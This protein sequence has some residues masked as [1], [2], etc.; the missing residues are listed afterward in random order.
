MNWLRFKTVVLGI[1]CVGMAHAQDLKKTTFKVVPSHLTAQFAGAMGAAALGPGFNYGKHKRWD[2]EVLL[3]YVPKFDSEK[4]KY[5]INFRQTYKPFNLHLGNH[6]SLYPLRTGA[7]VNTTIG[8]EF[9]MSTPEKYPS[10][11]YTFSTKLRLNIFAGQELAYHL[12][13][14]DLESIRFFYDIH[15]S[16]LYLISR[17]QNT[18]LRKRNYLGLALGVKLQ[19]KRF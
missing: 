5:T 18:Y 13:S 2:S 16:D 9:W 19:W 7:F 15:T 3:G 11:Y 10:K 6:L 4:V 1:F 17:I 8:K 14:K 12:K